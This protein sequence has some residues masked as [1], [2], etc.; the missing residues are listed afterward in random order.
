MPQMARAGAMLLRRIRPMCLC[1]C[2]CI[3]AACSCAVTTRLRYWRRGLA[4][5]VRKPALAPGRAGAPPRRRQPGRQ[6]RHRAC[7][8][9]SLTRSPRAR[10]A[11]GPP[12]RAAGAADRRRYD[13]GR[14]GECVC[15]SAAGCRRR[16][17]L[18]STC[19]SP[20]CVPD[21][22]FDVTGRRSRRHI[23]GNQP[24]MGACDP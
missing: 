10:L 18:R 9:R 19:W 20:R 3:G 8:P 12:G 2:R 4:R 11:R 1:P 23:S 5:V 21:P 24:P 22:R 15:A 6:V 13:L 7:S 17:S 16:G 14:H